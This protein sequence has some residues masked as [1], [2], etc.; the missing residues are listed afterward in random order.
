MYDFTRIILIIGRKEEASNDITM[1]GT[2]FFVSNDGKIVTARHVVGDLQKDL[3]VILPNIPNINT[4]QDVADLSCRAVSV[5]IEDV[6]PITDLC[7]LKIVGTCSSPFPVLGSLDAVIVGQRIG[8]FGYPHCVHGRRVLTYQETEIGAKM[9]LETSSIKSKYATINVQ[10]RPGQSGS[11]IFDIHSGTIL[12]L[13]IGS[14]APPSGISIA[15]INP[16][17]LNQTSYCISANHIK[18]ML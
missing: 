18:E 4:Y 2:G 10:T 15:G 8:I 3:C 7:I 13:L 9:L 14:Y 17:E 12:G 16:Y 11:I 6:N 1:L 5:T